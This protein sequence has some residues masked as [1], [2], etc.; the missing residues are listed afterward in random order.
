MSGWTFPYASGVE[1]TEAGLDVALGIDPGDL[2]P[3]R[4]WHSAE[5]AFISVPG[6]IEAILG[7]QD[8]G[9]VPAV[10]NVFVRTPTGLRDA[11]R[12]ETAEPSGL[13]VVFPMNN[14]QKCGNV[15][16][17][18]EGREQAIR[19]AH[20]AI[21][22][23]LVR[24]RPDVAVTTAFLLH[25]AGP[26]RDAPA[27]ALRSARAR[28]AFDRLP[29]FRGSAGALSYLTVDLAEEPP[30]SD[31]HGTGLL[32]ALRRVTEVT[33]IHPATDDGEGLR[34]GRG[35]WRSFLA[36]GAQGA[37]YYVDTVRR[38]MRD[39]RDISDLTGD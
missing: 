29:P 18:A 4:S 21:G 26:V 9:A 34:L 23:I 22:C 37:V 28:A 25:G 39:G 14:V 13:E 33:G 10:R 16:T 15:I 11:A 8:A 36:G 2:R 6:T 7:L 20:E 24:L 31:W 30:A 27:F 17:Q 5:R 38:R 19:S 32:E 3:T 1:V 12:G 35:F